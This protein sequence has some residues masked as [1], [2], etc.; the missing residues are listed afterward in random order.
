MDIKNLEKVHPKFKNERQCKNPKCGGYFLSEKP[1]DYCPLCRK[2]GVDKVEN[3]PDNVVHTEVNM[4]ELAK[5]VAELEAQLAEAKR[6]KPKS[7]KPK[8]CANCEKKFTPSAANQQICDPCR[9]VLT[10]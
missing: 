3:N 8:D 9:E 10:S 7:F 4:T 6:P 5:K 1:E 2:R